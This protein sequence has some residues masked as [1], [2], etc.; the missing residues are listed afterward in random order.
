VQSCCLDSDG[1][2][3]SSIPEPLVFPFMI[4]CMLGLGLF[5][6]SRSDSGTTSTC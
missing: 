6:I 1:N 3:S 2:R 5:R 4:F